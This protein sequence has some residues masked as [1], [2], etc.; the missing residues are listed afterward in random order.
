M[1]RSLT[2][3]RNRRFRGM[4][5]TRPFPRH[6]A[7]GNFMQYMKLTPTE[8][9]NELQ[10]LAAMKDFLVTS[11]ASLSPVEIRSQGPGGLLSPVE[12]VWHLADLEREGFGVRIQR[13]LAETEPQ[14]PDFDGARIAAER[15]YRSLSFEEGLRAFETARLA[16]IAIFNMLAPQAWMRCGTL[17]GVGAVSLCDMPELMRQH[18]EAHKTEI[19][20]WQLHR[21]RF[22]LSDSKS[23]GN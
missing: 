6:H 22:D 3:P 15:D 5:Q 2:I 17:D 8:Q 7:A 12:Q 16:N 21:Q 14:L 13:L 23:P 10:T 1:L 20:E 11:F 19:R 9:Q 4:K 18:D